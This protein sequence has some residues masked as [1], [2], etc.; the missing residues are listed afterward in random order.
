MA[1][2]MWKKCL[3]DPSR[4]IS[5]KPW[6]SVSATSLHVKVCGTRVASI[7][8][9]MQLSR[10]HGLLWT[11]D[12]IQFNWFHFTCISAIFNSH[13]KAY[14][15]ES[16]KTNTVHR[17]QLNSF[18]STVYSYSVHFTSNRINSK[19]VQ[20]S[21]FISCH[22]IRTWIFKD[23]NRLHQIFT[24]LQS[25]TLSK[26]KVSEE[27][28]KKM[29]RTKNIQQNQTLRGRPS[30]LSCLALLLTLTDYDSMRKKLNKT[31]HHLS[32]WL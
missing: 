19:W 1:D 23:H 15:T 10:L 30:V 14:D 20:N 32:R 17:I 16:T 4:H 8:T 18:Q 22:F 12:M 5:A 27:M 7:V 29:N 11:V 3:K 25:P 2:V 28:K 31:A 26:A 24:L 6:T 13:L 9:D 21:H